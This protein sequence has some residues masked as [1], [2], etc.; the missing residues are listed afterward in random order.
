[1]SQLMADSSYQCWAEELIGLCESQ[2]LSNLMSWPVIDSA[3]DCLLKH[4]GHIASLTGKVWKKGK[5]VSINYADRDTIL[6]FLDRKI[7]LYRIP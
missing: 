6:C 4:I 2:K 7:G 3:M 1:M 5:R